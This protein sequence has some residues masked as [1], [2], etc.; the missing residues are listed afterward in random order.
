MIQ[1]SWNQFD[2]DSLE[3]VRQIRDK[4]FNPDAVLGVPRGGVPL[5]VRISSLTGLPVVQE[6]TARTLI[7][8]DIYDSGRTRARYPGLPFFTIH[9]KRPDYDDGLTFYLRVV[10]D[11]I[12][13]PWEETREVD[14]EDIVTRMI[15]YLGDDPTREGLRDTPARVVKSW[16]SLFRG[17]RPEEF[18]KVTVF[19]NGQDGVFYKGMIIDHGYFFSFCEHHILPFF[20]HYYYGYIP[21]EWLLGASKI[22]RVIDFASSR[23][24]VAERLCTQIVDYLEGAVKPKGQILVMSGRHLCREMRGVKKFDSLFEVVEVRGCF[25]DNS[26]QCKE[27]FLK[28]ITTK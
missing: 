16:G 9:T 17:Y 23:L 26:H 6:A 13:Y 25:F 14:G 15:E 2:D 19:P 1:Y 4:G 5:A 22:A 10:D 18:P 28:R 12:V 7:V 8:D 11:W 21:D 20:G 3:M 24:Q 27:E